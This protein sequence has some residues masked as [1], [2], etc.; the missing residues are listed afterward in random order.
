MA[1]ISGS[2]IGSFKGTLGDVYVRK[3]NGKSQLIVRA[4]SI[5]KN[6]DPKSVERRQ[7]FTVTT[8]FASQVKSLPALNGIWVKLKGK[9]LSSH[10]VIFKANYH[11]I[12]PERP[13]LENIIVPEGFD[14]KFSSV[15]S[16]EN[17]IAASIPPLNAVADSKSILSFNCLVCF[18]EPGYAN[19]EK[20]VLFASS[21]DYPDL[22]FTIG[23]DLE[24]AF[25]AEQAEL[26]SKYYKSIVYLALVMKNEKGEYLQNS[27]SY[28]VQFG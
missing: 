15:L 24:I 12:L 16:A 4:R 1:T 23:H 7:K 14:P 3:I 6:N 2:V 28:S 17:K 13:A 9:M 10:N 19:R 20:Y 8:K 18:F 27:E 11:L 25:T 21:R 5:K 22:D 26:S